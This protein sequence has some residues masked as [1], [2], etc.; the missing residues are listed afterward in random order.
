[1]LKNCYLFESN[2]NYSTE[3]VAWYRGQM[4]EIDKLI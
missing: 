4:D 3:E 2:G 1:M